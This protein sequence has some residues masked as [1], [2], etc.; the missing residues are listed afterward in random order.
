MTFSLVAPQR[1]RREPA[2]MF[3]DESGQFRPRTNPNAL[4]HCLVVG[5]VFRDTQV[6]RAR[7]ASVAASLRRRYGSMVKA[8]HLDDDDYA[9]VG[10]LI[11][12]LGYVVQRGI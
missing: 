11:R 8:K 1:F 5:V 2:L 6:A 9:L 12:E 4:E 7:I 3:I 10:D